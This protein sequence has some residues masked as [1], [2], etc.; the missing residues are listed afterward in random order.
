[1][2]IKSAFYWATSNEPDA[3]AWRNNAKGTT[4]IRMINR[5]LDDGDKNKVFKI[6]PAEI[7][8]PSHREPGKFFQIPDEAPGTAS[9]YFTIP[10][11]QDVQEIAA[12]QPAAT[13]GKVAI[14]IQN[15]WLGENGR[16]VKPDRSER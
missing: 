9:T 3:V 14:H 13:N 2:T 1:M 5:A 7:T 10:Q 16:F 11:T 6:P 4:V 15:E 8:N 12:P